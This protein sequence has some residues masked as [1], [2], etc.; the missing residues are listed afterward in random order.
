MNITTSSRAALRPGSALD[1]AHLIRLNALGASRF[2]H[3]RAAKADKTVT[4]V[5]GN[6]LPVKEASKSVSS[7]GI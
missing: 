7:R 2:A 6:Y 3:A 5:D 1:R 4:V